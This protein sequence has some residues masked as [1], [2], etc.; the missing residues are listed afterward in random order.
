[1]FILVFIINDISNICRKNEMH[2]TLLKLALEVALEGALLLC[3]S[4]KG[5]GALGGGLHK[6]DRDGEEAVAREL[7]GL[8]QLAAS[9]AAATATAATETETET[10]TATAAT[11]GDAAAA[12]TSSRK[13]QS[14]PSLEDMTKLQG[15]LL[16]DVRFFFLLFPFSN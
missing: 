2:A 10:K 9:A 1:M 5:W 13:M 7:Y 15:L 12:A 6:K 3:L 4:A 11:A 14:L 16:L 8:Q